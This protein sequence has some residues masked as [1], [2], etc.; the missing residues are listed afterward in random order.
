MSESFNNQLIVPACTVGLVL[1]SGAIG[2]HFGAKSAGGAKSNSS[3]SSSSSELLDDDATNSEEEDNPRRDAIIQE[4]IYT[5]QTYV[6]FLLVLEEI[7]YQPLDTL[8]SFQ[9]A[10]ISKH[11]VDLIFGN[12]PKIRKSNQR[13]L[14]LLEESQDSNISQI[15][16]SM[17]EKLKK[18]HKPY[19]E[20]FTKARVRKEYLVEHNRDFER[21]LRVIR[22]ATPCEGKTLA[23]ILIMPV[24]R[25]PRYEMLLNDL[26]KYTPDDHPEYTS[27]QEALTKLHEISVFMNEN[28]RR[29]EVLRQVS[30]SISGF[31]NV[32]EN[33]ERT[34]LFE[35]ECS[36]TRGKM[37]QQ[38]TLF[39][40][41][42]GFLFTKKKSKKIFSDNDYLFKFVEF[43]PVSHET[44]IEACSWRPNGKS[45][46]EPVLYGPEP[47]TNF[48]I[49]RYFATAAKVSQPI[50][51]T[52]TAP[53]PVPEPS[54]EKRLLDAAK[55]DA[56]EDVL[57][58]A[59]YLVEDDRR[60]EAM[61]I[62][63]KKA[64]EGDAQAMMYLAKLFLRDEEPDYNLVEYW[65][66]LAADYQLIEAMYVSFV[67]YHHDVL[68]NICLLL[69][70]LL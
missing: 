34:F 3:S 26:L 44:F 9:D 68:A 15:F 45:E 59:E 57:A 14:H 23:D 16:L 39:L 10:V 49:L 52:T 33:S 56:I 38:Y 64:K 48:A 69:E 37:P 20:N 30:G 5:E 55:S 51:P 50:D 11:D 31:E 67:G 18:S 24:Q 66:K 27:I 7:F 22:H 25:M 4:I 65:A 21:F 43:V 17:M 28:N 32:P 35:G 1:V 62:V 60:D 40:F 41:D 63:Q 42:D 2:Y 46:R 58:L 13:L 47:V 61:E 54:L 12:V 36:A 53:S 70:V 29:I 8:S 6:G 19:L